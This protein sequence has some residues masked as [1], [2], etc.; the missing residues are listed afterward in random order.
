[1]PITGSAAFSF[2]GMVTSGSG[3]LAITGSADFSLQGMTT[4]SSGSL[5]ITGDSHIILDPMGEDSEAIIGN[6]NEGSSDIDFASMAVVSSA[7]GDQSNGP[8]NYEEVFQTLF[9]RMAEMSWTS[10]TGKKVKLITT[11]RRV[12]LFADV[13]FDQQAAGFQAEHGEISE[14]K[15]GLPYKTVLEANWIIYQC[16]GNSK[17]QLGAIENNRILQSA[18]KVLSPK[19]QDVGFFEKRNTLGGLVHHCFISG[20]IFKDPGD[21]DGQGMLVIPIK[22]LVP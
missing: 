9:E 11:S 5:E 12:K 21:I 20:R 15:T 13:P 14:Q 18:R 16:V 6:G 22:L 19:P 4:G 2:Y 3:S 8:F 17:S 10:V 1:M 7:I